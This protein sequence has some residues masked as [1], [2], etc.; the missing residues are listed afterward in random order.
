MATQNKPLDEEGIVIKEIISLGYDAYREVPN[1]T[2]YPYAVVQTLA[3]PYR[4][5]TV[6]DCSLEID[7]YGGTW[8]QARDI[9]KNLALNLPAKLIAVSNVFNVSVD[10]RYRDD[11]VDTKT[12]RCVLD[13]SFTLIQPIK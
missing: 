4:I 7:I 11:D 3:A 2:E 5:P 13:I 8:K 9:G 12:P 6:C 1:D 10:N